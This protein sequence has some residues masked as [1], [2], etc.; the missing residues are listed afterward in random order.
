MSVE[1]IRSRDSSNLSLL[2]VLQSKLRT[3]SS[4]FRSQLARPCAAGYN[5][6]SQQFHALRR[7]NWPVLTSCR[8]KDLRTAT[9]RIRRGCLWAAVGADTAQHQ[10]MTAKFRRRRL[11]NRSAISAMSPL[12]S[13]R[14]LT[15]PGMQCVSPCPLHQMPA[16]KTTGTLHRTSSFELCVYATSANGIICPW[17]ME[18]WNSTYRNHCGCAA[19][20]IPDCRKWRNASWIPTRKRVGLEKRA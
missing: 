18:T 4:E 16:R 1:S 3:R 9:G 13:G 10:G 5:G 17:S 6:E 20:T 12:V 11:W 19:T 14:L 8:K 7:A 2:R 15:G